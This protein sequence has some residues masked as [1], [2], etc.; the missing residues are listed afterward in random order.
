MMARARVLASGPGTFERLLFWRFEFALRWPTLALRMAAGV[1][2]LAR[3]AEE[4]ALLIDSLSFLA[5]QVSPFLVADGGSGPDFIGYLERN[6]FRW[7]RLE[8][9]EATLVKQIKAAMSGAGDSVEG[10]LLYTE[11]DK[12]WF[13]ENRLAR[14]LSFARSQPEAGVIVPSRSD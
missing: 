7:Q 5:E 4:T 1:P 12:R 13:F 2:T 14:S 10:Q 8:R 9:P 3:D 11:P 6:S